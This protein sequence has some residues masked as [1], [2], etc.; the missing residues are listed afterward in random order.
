MY[1]WVPTLLAHIYKELFF[2]S[3]RHRASLSV[4][5]MLQTWAYEHITMAHPLRLLILGF[6]NHLEYKVGIIQWYDDFY[7]R[8]LD[9]VRW[10]VA[11]YHHMLG[12][13]VST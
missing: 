9:S 3:Q 11:Y 6:G 12:H 8:P 7:I 13:L 5:I 4:T 1:A 2:Y 10:D